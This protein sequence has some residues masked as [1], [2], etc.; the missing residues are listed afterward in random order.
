MRRRRAFGATTALLLT[1]GLTA[2]D[3]LAQW[4][5]QGRE[6]FTTRV[7]TTGLEN[8]WEITWGPDRQLWVTEK[9]SGRVTRV[10]PS[11]GSKSTVLTIPDNLATDKAQDGLLGLALDRRLLRGSPYLYVSS[12]YDGDPNPAVLDRRQKLTRY[13][14][15]REAKTAGRPLDLITGLPASNDHNSGRLKLGPD[16]KLYYTLGDLGGNQY[17][18]FCTPIRSQELPTAAEVGARDF[19]KYQGKI[20]RL[21]AD[22]SIPSDNPTIGGVKSHIYTYGHRNPQGIV[23][24]P[25]G[26][27]YANEHGPKS[28]DEHNLIRAG[29]NY[30]WPRVLGFK[31]NKA[32]VYS[33]WSAS[34][35]VACS[36]LTY[37]DFRIPPSVPQQR[38]STFTEPFVDPIKTTFTVSSNFLFED[39]KCAQAVEFFPC[40]PTLAPS[41]L[42]FYTVEDG[43]P[44]WENSLLTTGLKYG[45]LYRL[46]LSDD[47][48]RVR[49]GPV[50]YW[51]TLNRY[52]DLAQNPDGKTFYVATDKSGLGGDRNRRPI[53]TFENP[54]AILVF[55]YRGRSG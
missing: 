17:K 6:P 39:P 16:G 26:K 3:A 21:N 44:G 50:S 8:P 37:S 20:L 53:T 5:P 55:K 29:K 52:R 30:G 38:E 43:V 22:G 49:G 15:D 33:N 18:N 14:Y 51:R 9:S 25:D 40:W 27:L 41:S 13:T 36:S 28:D 11:D 54:G 32:Y 23:F 34:S 1:M 12:S 2:T 7:L 24:G 42:D 4:A 35:G 19:T 31:D 45:S 47:G 48:R 10:N 46:K